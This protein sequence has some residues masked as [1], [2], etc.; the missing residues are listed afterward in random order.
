MSSKIFDLPTQDSQLSTN[1]GI[2]QVWY[3]RINPQRSVSSTASFT[4]GLLNWTWESASGVWWLPSKSYFEMTVAYLKTG[5][6]QP[7]AADGVAPA[8]NAMAN[9]F[10]TLSFSINDKDICNLTDYVAQCDTILKRIYN[11]DSFIKNGYSNEFW[12]TFGLRVNK[13][14]ANGV[15]VF[16]NDGTPLAGSCTTMQQNEVVIQWRPMCLAIFRV[17]EAIPANA[18][19]RLSAQPYS[20]NLLGNAYESKSD[21]VKPV[22]PNIQNLVFF[23]AHVQ[24]PRWGD[25]KDSYMLDL[26]HITCQARAVSG[27]GLSSN[28]FDIP[29]TTYA[30]SLAYQTTGVAVDPGAAVSSLSLIHI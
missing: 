24:G 21:T 14:S 11:S 20:T 28:Q 12:D 7:N 16:S 9:L 29:P 6:V 2:T 5:S 27:S 22:D 17:E 19:F 10:Q 25:V 18:R 13:V 8:L 1:E 30:L 4:Q 23:A 26:K 15:E 3:D